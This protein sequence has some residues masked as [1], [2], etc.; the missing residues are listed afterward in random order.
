MGRNKELL[1]VDLFLCKENPAVVYLPGLL[2]CLPSFKVPKYL[3]QKQTI[4][5]LAISWF[6]EDFIVEMVA[7]ASLKL[8]VLMPEASCMLE[9]HLGTTKLTLGWPRNSLS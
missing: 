4:R 3:F 6:S 1:V 5:N 2:W 8:T 9:L 7:Q